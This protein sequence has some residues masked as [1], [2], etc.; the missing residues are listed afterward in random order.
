MKIIKLKEFITL[1]DE[2]LKKSTDPKELFNSEELDKP[3]QILDDH[4]SSKDDNL[5]EFPLDIIVVINKDNNIPVAILDKKEKETEIMAPRKPIGTIVR[6]STIVTNTPKIYNKQDIDPSSFPS[7]PSFVSDEVKQR[8]IYTNKNNTQSNI[9]NF[10]MISEIAPRTKSLIFNIDRFPSPPDD[11]DNNI[12]TVNNTSNNNNSSGSGMSS[13]DKYVVYDIDQFPDAP[14]SEDFS[15][16]SKMPLTTSTEDAPPSYDAISISNKNLPSSS[17]NNNNIYNSNIN[18]SPSQIPNQY[19]IIKKDKKSI[20]IR[21]SVLITGCL[22]IGVMISTFLAVIIGKLLLDKGRE[23]PQQMKRVSYVVGKIKSINT[24]QGKTTSTLL[25]ATTT[26]NRP[27]PTYVISSN[28]VKDKGNK[29]ITSKVFFK[30]PDNTEVSWKINEMDDLAMSV[31]VKDVIMK[32]TSRNKK[33]DY[34][35]DYKRSKFNEYILDNSNSGNSND[36]NDNSSI[37]NSNN[38]SINTNNNDTNN[39]N[40]NSDNKSDNKSNNKKE[41]D[42]SNNY[43]PMAKPYFNPWNNFNYSNFNFNNKD[44]PFNKKDDSNN[45]NNSF[46]TPPVAPIM[47]YPGQ[48]ENESGVPKGS[49]PKPEQ[50]ITF[51]EI[52]DNDDF[53]MKLNLQVKRI[54]ELPYNETKYENFI[55]LT[56]ENEYDK[57]TVVDTSKN[58]SGGILEIKR[59]FKQ[60]N[61]ETKKTR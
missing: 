4:F 5:K 42:H 56:R 61:P 30:D 33:R 12:I 49:G 16:T 2:R 26:V 38:N 32:N 22:C 48:F 17:N 9:N 25:F 27:F 19:E 60:I 53:S 8:D 24:K 59:V 52:V 44:N 18:N 54:M 11:N 3:F 47:P 36:D 23:G 14:V 15:I 50:Q 37:N 35:F 40:N 28:E 43:N 55:D 45:G 21:K 41:E 1:D 13:K 51:D 7:P 10:D 57:S 6:E 20:T 34:Y 39:K 31:E 58:V 46:Y 29:E